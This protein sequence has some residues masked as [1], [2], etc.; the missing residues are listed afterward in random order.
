PAKAKAADTKAADEKPVDDKPADDKAKD[1]KKDDKK[2]DEKPAEEPKK[3]QKFKPLSEVHDEI[4]TKLAQ[5]IA[6]ETR[7]KAVKEVTDAIN[8]YGSRY[9]RWLS[10]K[11]IKK[12][13]AQEPAKLDLEAIAAKHGFKAGTTP[14][15]DQYEVQAY[16]IGKD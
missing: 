16:D 9:R 7:T 11:E 8:D 2:G 12:D 4:Q 3:D 13:A 10:V 5:P 6:Q 14:L 1:E 15:V